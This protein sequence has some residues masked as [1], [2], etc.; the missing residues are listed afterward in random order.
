MPSDPRQTPAM[1][2]YF[3][4]KQRHPDCLLLFRMGDFY[5]L[6]DDD[7][8]RAHKLL[9]ITLTQRTEGVPMAGVP[10]H[11]VEG[12][13]RRLVSQGV[14][15][16]VCDQIQDPK[17]A[18][19]VVER[20]VTRVIT[21]GTLVDESLLGE[22]ANNL[23]AVA[24]LGAGDD[25]A[26]PAS[27]AIVEV[28][29]GAFSVLSCSAADLLDEL[30]RRR[31]SELLY[32]E[33]ADGRP[34]A[35]VQRL[36]SGLGA[37]GT[38]RPAW[39]F[40]AAEAAEA[41]KKHYGVATLAG[42]GLADD[43]PTLPAAGAVLRYLQETQALAG[44]EG[45]AA[46]TP[47][48]D[49]FSSGSAGAFV[50]RQRSLAHLAP[51]RRDDPAR[52]L[53][54]DA[55]S[56]RALEVERTLRGAAGSRGGEDGSADGS[57]L[58][59]FLRTS[60]S[61]KGCRTPM[62]RRLVREWLCRPASDRSVIESRQ[63]C[64]AVLVDDPRSA[65]ALGEALAGVQDVARITARAGLGRATPRDLA[66]LAASLARV[67]R[68]AAAIAEAPA[69]GAHHR[70]LVRL[71]GALSPVAG[72]IAR[73]CVDDPPAHLR[74]G[75]LIR[76]GVDP[77]L[78][79]AR[80]LQKDSAAWLA[81]YQARL[82]QEFDLP[83]LKV[84]F[85]KIFGYYI[86]LPAA[87]SRR[88]PDV[89]S[90]KQT[91]KNAE[92]YITPEL[93][94]YEDKVLTAGERAIR[95]EGEMFQH[96][97]GLVTAAAGDAARFAETV[98]EL[99]VLAC[100]AARAVHRRWTRPAIADDTRLEIAEGRH[101]VLE[102]TLGPDFVPNDLR[103]G[104]AADPGGE[105]PATLALIT[106]PNMAGKST[107]IRQVA[108]IA[109]LA[110]TGSFVPAASATIGLLDRIF[111][112]VG[113][114]DAL[115]AGQS[116]F[117]VEMVETANI[118]HHATGRSLVILD[119][120]GRGTS[121]LDG[122]S[123]AWAVAEFLAGDDDAPP[124]PPPSPSTNA[125]S[126]GRPLT[127]FATH[128]HELTDLAERLPGRV[129]NLHVSVREWGEEIVFLHRILPGRASRSY[130]IH[131]AKLAGLPAEVVRRAG[132][133]L[134]SISVTHSGAGDPSGDTGG[135]SRGGSGGGS[136]GGAGGAAASDRGR[137]GA[138]GSRIAAR[139]HGAQMALF[140][141]V[142]PHPTIEGRQRLDMDRLTP[143][144]GF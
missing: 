58:S 45:S 97:C 17:E 115:H 80:L 3:A 81:Q 53:R 107:Y 105:G 86:E 10:F 16:A 26:G 47:T 135:G 25:P 34:P 5:E 54:L 52:F 20:A 13:L 57:L 114:D 27:A 75:G 36:L 66:A 37:S 85:N 68:L 4:F 126:A 2:Q 113:A 19:G 22:A 67:D 71:S 42:F 31:P 64:V 7:A 14:R 23:A 78:D 6:F 46:A 92:R 119:E 12:Y 101:P 104:A 38:A 100:F 123:L 118:L 134:D 77:L 140:T 93:K 129:K 8:V 90:R 128:Y 109:L 133:V 39:H 127:L 91:L 60:G 33:T 11:S 82:I 137:A 72:E 112:R 108:L 49:G 1:R 110:H 43:D 65:A 103:L 84:G 62:G 122:L 18:K 131:V 102:E 138:P 144:Q 59:L 74:E 141:E 88:A 28:S 24:F 41:L 63:A 89:F 32:A 125:T 79:E 99:D 132:E 136:G 143:I 96:L 15:V 94:A 9:G 40:R 29:T 73:L 61:F 83:S 117:M 21:P 116:T 106:G 56:L 98:A 121:T 95:R 51:P 69:F 35:R 50:P 124:D 139:R 87:Q 120:I 111:T 130:G 70:E 44:D 48:S 142:L 30:A 55:V 76:D